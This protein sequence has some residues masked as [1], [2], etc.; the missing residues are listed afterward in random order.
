MARIERFGIGQTAKVLGVLYGLMGVVVVPFF[1]VA[2][3]FSPSETGF[4]LGFAIMVP[5]LYGL[6]GFVF[7]A[8]GCWLYNVVAGWIGGIEID[9]G[10]TA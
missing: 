5:I 3:M 6:F 1:M 7:T 8:I 4:G 9:L 10:H 2:T